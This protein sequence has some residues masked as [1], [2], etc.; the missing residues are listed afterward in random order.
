M[1]AGKY[2][3]KYFLQSRTLK[4]K[5]SYKDWERIAHVFLAEKIAVRDPGN[6]PQSGDRIEFAVIKVKNDDPKKK[7]LQGEKIETPLFIKQN[8]L[9]VD[10]LFYMTNQIQNPAIQFMEI[11]DKNI[12][13][14]FEEY[15]NKFGTPKPVKEKKVKEVKEKK[16]RVPRKKIVKVETPK[17]EINDDIVIDKDSIIEPKKI[18]KIKKTL[19]EE[20]QEL[21]EKPIIKEHILEEP[22]LEE[23]ILEE[24]VKKVKK[25]KKV[26]EELIEK[27]IIEE[28]LIKE[29]VK[30]VKKAEEVIEVPIK[31]VNKPKKVIE[32]PIKEVIE[33]KPIIE[34]K[35]I[36]KTIKIVNSEPVEENLIKPIKKEKKVKL[37][38]DTII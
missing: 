24:P 4:M 17:V 2:D 12:S 16:P 26:V 6:K 30:K 33:D 36:K 11:V 34:V 25:S 38:E 32:E 13:E 1:F 8:N 15:K 14:L 20:I 35:K 18:K 31:K 21:I 9:E 5:E 10:Y 27:P 3:I 19:V 28:P 22:I 7:M 29:S 23:P 37:I